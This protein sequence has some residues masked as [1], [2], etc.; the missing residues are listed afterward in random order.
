[1][2]HHR[3]L[4]A[5]ALVLTMAATAPAQTV[6]FD[7]MLM[8]GEATRAVVLE[9][10][11]YTGFRL[12]GLVAWNAA[13]PTTQRHFTSRDG[14]GG[15]SVTDLVWTGRNL[16]VATQDGGLTRL[17]DPGATAPATRVFASNLSSIAV[18][19]V[20]GAIVGQTE[21]VY[22]GTA[23]SGIGVINDGLAGGYY[24][25]ADGLLDDR[26]TSLALAGDQLFVA[27]PS[28]VARFANNVFTTINTG[29]VTTVNRLAI[30]DQGRT[31]AATLDGVRRWDGDL[32]QW[33]VVAGAGASYVDI[34]V[35]GA[36]IWLMRIDGVP[37]LL[38]G[39]ALSSPGL[40]TPLPDASMRI[41]AVG[42]GDGE[43]WVAGRYRPGPMQ[44][45]DTAS[46]FAWVGGRRGGAWDQWYRESSVVGDG[47][48]VTFDGAGRAW[49]GE[50]G[51]DGLSGLSPAGDW[52]H[53]V[54][55]ATVANDSSGLFNQLGGVLGAV[56]DAAGDLWFSQFFSGVIHVAD[57]EYDLIFPG[58]SPLDGSAVVRL[59]AHPDGPIFIMTD[60]NVP[61]SGVQV[62]VDPQQ[63]RR[64]DAWV[65]PDVG[66]TT[67]L[68]ALAERRD[69]IW[70]AVRGVGLVRWDVNGDGGPDDELTWNAPQDDT[71]DTFPTIAGASIDLSQVQALALGADG[72]IWVAS[73]RVL[74]FIYNVPGG[75]DEDS[76]VEFRVKDNAAF[77]GL[78]SSA[79]VG[80]AVDR[81]QHVWALTS[82]GLNR[83]RPEGNSWSIDA[84]TD[85]ETFLSLAG[86][87]LYSSNIL[88]ALPGGTYRQL[89]ANATGEQLIVSSDRGATRLTV[90]AGTDGA[91]ADD[92][93]ADLFLYPNPFSGLE[94]D[95]RLHLGGLADDGGTAQA[96]V[97]ILNLQGQIVYRLSSLDPDT[98][99]FAGAVTRTNERVA[100]GLYV[101]KVEYRGA[102]AVRT[103]AVVN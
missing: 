20:T 54:D 82:A 94:G 60:D 52:Q 96:T 28:G 92:A 98:G 69:V 86:S 47:D 100:S 32:G 102:T 7:P 70:F 18:T 97:E 31:L 78:L 1:M 46:G 30:D 57:G 29:L 99:F 88:A 44:T 25:T 73:N 13:D 9:G 49:V 39:D 62:L 101:V 37:Q 74:S 56:A 59:A 10:W 40:P 27:T 55:L 87:G 42:G 64:G 45:N 21:R 83:I 65:T 76:L 80:L 67:V 81:N 84:Y 33:T 5:I 50:R 93:L 22:Y 38:R 77:Q 48:G 26:I 35:D 71:F 85:L 95:T 51:G 15:A 2:H 3:W 6:T 23:A 63:W 75:F 43:V 79:V 41:S 66:G 91:P 103:L 8:A 16:W 14:L 19:A 61:Q 90:A 34:S 24:S 53:I 17:T 36:D 4:V 72:R 11:V 12:G 68:A 89:A 58:N